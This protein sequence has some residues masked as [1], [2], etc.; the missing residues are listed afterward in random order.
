MAI[1]PNNKLNTKYT[2]KH[3]AEIMISYYNYIT[4]T[5]FK[6]FSIQQYKFEDFK[7]EIF[8]CQHKMNDYRNLPSL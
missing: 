6:M 3:F 1:R 2:E 4:N 8:S 7:V 5:T